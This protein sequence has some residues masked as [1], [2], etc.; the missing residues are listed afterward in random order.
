TA[1]VLLLVFWLVAIGVERLIQR[2]GEARRVA[3]DAMF[4]LSRAAKLSLLAVGLVTALGTLGINVTALVTGLGLT[5]FAV[6][7]ALKDIISNTLAGI[8]IL[9]Y[10]PFQ[11][12]DRILVPS[13]PV[14]LEGHVVQVDLRYTTLQLPDR[15]ILIPNANLFTN[16]IMVFQAPAAEAAPNSSAPLK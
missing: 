7:F 2:A 1:V 10:K 12:Q 15:K 9:I 6:G 4:I 13:V 3:S 14:N 16:P 11:R 5:G 8:L